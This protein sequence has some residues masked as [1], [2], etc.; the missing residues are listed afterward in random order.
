MRRSTKPSPN[1]V[2]RPTTGRDPVTS[3]RSP[4]DLAKA[5][6][7]F[8]EATGLRG[9]STAIRHLVAFALSIAKAI[10][11]LQR[12]DQ[13]QDSISSSMARGRLAD[14]ARSCLTVWWHH[15]ILCSLAPLPAST[16][17]SP[18][19]M[20]CSIEKVGLSGFSDVRPATPTFQL[21]SGGLYVLG[22]ETRAGGARY[23][24]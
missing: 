8:S 3:V 21:E 2:K 23:R 20:G 5:I 15:P 6:D 22:R 24:R 9:R 12:G 13:H 4:T 11:P 16:I 7:A 1:T 18:A 17:T 10:E 14:A 19:R